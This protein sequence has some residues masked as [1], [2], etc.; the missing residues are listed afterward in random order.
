MGF[1]RRLCI[2][3]ASSALSHAVQNTEELAVRSAGGTSDSK[4]GATAKMSPKLGYYA[5]RGMMRHRHHG[6][7]GRGAAGQRP[8]PKPLAY[9]L[10]H[11][12]Q[13]PTPEKIAKEM[14]KDM[15]RKKLR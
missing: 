11:P 1:L 3:L 13:A 14:A 4:E 6:A 2:F 8:H 12:R 5:Q 7:T 9:Y 15:I 10:M